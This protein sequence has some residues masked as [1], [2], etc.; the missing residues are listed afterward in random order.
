ME[1]NNGQRTRQRESKVGKK[2]LR[3]H[4]Y[5]AYA[6]EGKRRAQSREGREMDDLLVQLFS[7]KKEGGSREVKFLFKSVVRGGEASATVHPQSGR[8]RETKR[9]E[10]G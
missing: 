3:K 5:E 4:S 2:N 1:E 8:K 9:T 10:T 6:A 7:L